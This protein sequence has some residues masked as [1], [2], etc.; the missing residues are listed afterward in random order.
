MLI[1]R[2]C[3]LNVVFKVIFYVS[4][5]Y[6]V[7]FG[8]INWFNIYLLY[9]HLFPAPR[10]WH[11]S[12]HEMSYSKIE[13]KLN[14]EKKN[15]KFPLTFW[16]PR[17]VRILKLCM[18]VFWCVCVRVFVC[19]YVCGRVF[20]CACVCLCVSVRVC[21]CVCKDNSIRKINRSESTFED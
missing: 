6:F 15:R 8:F 19:V 17:N 16:I 10:G 9:Y 1:G 20:V 4:T 2:R 3:C 21:V 18:F 7:Y 12:C 14:K 11:A 13:A 5:F